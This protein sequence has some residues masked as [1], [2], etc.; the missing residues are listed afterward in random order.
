MVISNQSTTNQIYKVTYREIKQRRI[1]MAHDLLKAMFDVERNKCVFDLGNAWA[2]GFAN[3]ERVRFKVIAD[4]EG[5][6]FTVTA[7]DFSSSISKSDIRSHI[8]FCICADL[9][10]LMGWTSSTDVSYYSGGVLNTSTV[11]NSMLAW[12]RGI[13]N[14]DDA[15]VLSPLKENDKN[16]RVQRRDVGSDYTMDE[17]AVYNNEFGSNTRLIMQSAKVTGDYETR[18]H[19]N[20]AIKMVY[21]VQSDEENWSR[22]ADLITHYQCAGEEFLHYCSVYG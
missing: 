1:D 3:D 7:K 19:L 8:Y 13:F 17:T 15:R 4:D 18:R 9:C 14:N 5:E 21:H 6:T 12:R 10:E 22:W 2:T 11:D 20:V 16:C